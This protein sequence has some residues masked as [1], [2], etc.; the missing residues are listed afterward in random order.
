MVFLFLSYVN[1]VCN[2]VI[3][4][5]PEARFGTSNNLLKIPIDGFRGFN[6]LDGTEPYYLSTLLLS[7]K[8]A[9]RPL[10]N[11]VAVYYIL[12]KNN[13]ETRFLEEDC[14]KRFTSKNSYIRYKV[15]FTVYTN[16]TWWF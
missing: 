14:V 8:F 16:F 3:I 1:V 10:P 7:I 6:N 5:Y 4:T 12:N 11:K 15:L 2:Y 9:L 13:E